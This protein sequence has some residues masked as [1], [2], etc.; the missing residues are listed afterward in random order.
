M[1]IKRHNFAH[2]MGPM[3]INR[4]SV[5]AFFCITGFSVN[6]KVVFDIKNKP[7]VLDTSRIFDIDEIVVV[8]QPKENYR[9]RM[10]AL[11]SSSFSRNDMS[12]LKVNS[13]CDLSTYAPSFSMPDYG[14]RLTSSIYVRGIGSRINS[15]AIGLYVD[16]MPIINKSALN[17]YTYQLERID[18]LRGPQ[19]TLYGQNTEGGL[20]RLY[21]PNPM[22]YNG[23]DVKLSIGSHFLRNIEIAHY[24]KIND[25]FAFSVAGFYNGCNGFLRNTTTGERADKINEAGGKTRL[26]YDSGR[27]LFLD[28]VADY[29]YVKQNG[30]AYGLYDADKAVT[31]DPA[32]NYQNNYRRNIFNTGLTVR[33]KEE[34]FDLNATTSYQYL[35]DYM[36]MDQD[37][38]PTDYMHLKQKQF[39][40]AITEEIT[41]KS[42]NDI[43]WKWTFG[44]FGSYMWLKTNAPVY[45]GEGMTKPISDKIQNVMYSAIVGSIAQK[46]IAGGMPE[47]VAMEM[48]KSIV[49][50]AGG[51]SLDMAMTVPGIFHTPHFNFGLFHE[52]NINITD[53]LNATIGFRYDFSQTKIKYNTTAQM[54]MI[55][56]VMGSK[57]T[58]TLSSHI[59]N[60]AK[61]NFSQLL[62]KFGLTYRMDN[63]NS[64]L[65]ISV[66]KGYRAGGYNIQMFSDILQTELMN[67]QSNAM[68][69]DYDVPHTKEDYEKINKTIAYKP[70]T[71]WNYEVGT[72]INLPDNAIS[73]DVS[74]YL[75]QVN[76]QQLSVM[77]GNYGFGRMMVNAGKSQSC[78]IEATVR[79]KAF[80]NHLS[81]IVN[82][83]FTHAVFKEYK[84]SIK[85]DGKNIQ[86]DYKDKKIPYIPV[87]TVGADIAYRLDLAGSKIESLTF[88]ANLSAQGKIYWDEANSYSQPFY[89]LIGARVEGKIG[90]AILTLWGKNITNTRYNT[91][92]IDSSA[93]GTRYCFAQRGYPVQIGFDVR[94]S[95]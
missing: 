63:N 52:S 79:G 29:Q 94:L 61:D 80:N 75:M 92:A 88:G 16:G 78:G 50:K 18:V 36:L 73:F 47:S 59:L 31:A 66:S 7:E 34:N 60:S 77:A 45:F 56:S 11:S 13:L 5:M 85:V 48:A 19:G 38:M 21:T 43:R 12:S 95:L 23:T 71:S 91:F 37:Y 64:N 51:V 49:D 35:K 3:N 65:Y 46:M 32:S 40:N 24:S 84:D 74:A 27:N 90:N 1:C 81:W 57:A 62:P 30:F 44:M 54:D 58:Y 17:F 76:N 67:N 42:K 14:S 69:G 8:S 2:K 15:P 55:A 28:F 26:V 33:L 53:R 82:Y 41:I 83:G 22:S 70:E 72:H 93:T 9:L 6:A 86:C 89:A 4:L 68:N 39:Q 10:Q 20:I 87:H 25:R